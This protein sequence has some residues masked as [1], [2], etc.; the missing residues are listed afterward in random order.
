MRSLLFFCIFIA[1]LA[2]ISAQTPS[3]RSQNVTLLGVWDDTNILP[4]GTFVNSRYS[5]CWGYA[6][7]GREY[8]VVGA[9]NGVHIIEVTNPKN[10]VRRDFVAGKHQN[11]VWREYKTY[12]KYLY[13]ISDDGKPNSFQILDLSYLPD[14]VKV[15]YDGTL[16]F[17][18][19]HTIFIDKDKMYIAGGDN[20]LVVYSLANPEK[21]TLLRSLVQD[22]P[23]TAWAHDMFVR[24]DTIFGSFG[25][26]GMYIYHF[27]DENKKFNLLGSIT[28]YPA[29]GYNH[30]SLLMPNGKTLVMAD[31]VPNSLP[32]KIF[33]VSNLNDIK[34]ETTF[35]SGSK[36]TPHNPFLAPNNRVAISFYEDGVQI[37]DVQNPK[38]P[39]K[40]GFFDSHYQSDSLNTTGGYLGNWSVYTELPSK[41]L[42]VVDMQNGLYVL[43]ARKAYGLLPI[44]VSD[45]DK[46]EVVRVF[47]NPVQDEVIFTSSRNEQANVSV[48]DITGK[49]LLTFK[50]IQLDGFRF[51]TNSL[52][53][54]GVYV[55]KIENQ[56][57]TQSLKIVKQ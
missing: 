27:D 52:L 22:F 41:N 48:F 24:N 2:S 44:G 25:Y 21:P 7:N 54:N 28:K 10:L 49:E 18:R 23:T 15:V 20:A 35:S 38:N 29:S 42:I 19:G 43:D 1:F 50:N 3:Y 34:L 9:Q 56:Y 4:N 26:S 17:E 31:E 39:I 30:S 32:L 11:A 47:P 33:D 57:F 40:T 51:S 8:A 36:A 16:P 45:V 5:S 13:C 55:L 37:F 6:G 46:E 14:S 53:S 12:G